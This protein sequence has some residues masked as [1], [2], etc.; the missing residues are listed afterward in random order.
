MNRIIKDLKLIFNQKKQSNQPSKDEIILN[1]V[2]KTIKTFN[3][4]K[5][6]IF[7]TEIKGYDQKKNDIF[8]GNYI[9]IMQHV[10]DVLKENGDKSNAGWLESVITQ[11]N[12]DC[13]L[14]KQLDGSYMRL[15]NKVLYNLD[16]EDII[17]ALS[18]YVY[19]L[20]DIKNEYQND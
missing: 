13:Y 14:S 5:Y 1:C 19:A 12:H 6:V 10:I 11:T 9:Q 3:K 15:K 16:R 18:S 8:Y 7:K 4:K 20:T 17:K 2:E